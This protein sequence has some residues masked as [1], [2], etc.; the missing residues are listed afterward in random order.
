[1]TVV[2]QWVF[3]QVVLSEE[4]KKD[5]LAA[6]VGIV[7]EILFSTHLYTL[8][9]EIYLQK[10]GGPTGLRGTCPIVRV[11][12]CMWDTMWLDRMKE[13]GLFI[14]KYVR[15]MDD[16]RA[17]LPAIRRGWRWENGDLLNCTRW[18]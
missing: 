13:K 15:Y 18:E 2:V 5:I 10:D 8:G 11:V 1:M 17:F 12:M 9:G 3:P 7:V 4:E 16:G 6:V 14:Q